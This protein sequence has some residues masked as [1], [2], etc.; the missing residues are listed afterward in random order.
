MKVIYAHYSKPYGGDIKKA[1]THWAKP[2]VE[3]LVLAYSA[4]KSKEFFGNNTLVV[5]SYSK[6]LIIDDLGLEFDEVH[7]ELDDCERNPMFWAAGKLY[8]YTKFIKEFE[9]FM[10][11]DNDAGFHEK[12][13]DYY[14]KSLYRCQHIHEDK[15]NVFGQY[16]K[17]LVRDTPNVFPYDIYHEA[18]KHPDGV[19]G[20]NAGMVICNDPELWSEFT[21]YTWAVMESDFMQKLARGIDQKKV[22]GHMSYWNVVVE[23][24]LLL[25]LYRRLRHELPQTF[26]EFKGLSPTPGTPNPLKYF[27]IWGKKSNIQVLNQFEKMAVD[28]LPEDL[29][30]RIYDYFR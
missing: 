23:E 19:K 16:I 10:F 12:P 11:C 9:P 21:R 3:F 18:V 4:Y 15:T 29:T 7:V 17:K 26:F 2:Y 6:K 28:Y 5:D 20:G 14:F 1:K 8:A 27:H 13:P 25:Q 24:I 22:F 30:K